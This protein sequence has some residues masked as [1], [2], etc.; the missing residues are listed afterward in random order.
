MSDDVLKRLAGTIH[1]RRHAAAD[2]SY[3]RQLLDGGVGECAKKFGE[4]AVETVLAAATEDDAALTREAADLLYHLL[5][6]LE[7]REIALGDVLK[8]LEERMGVSGLDEKA[9][10]G[11]GG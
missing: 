3:T 1:D 7:S 8:V 6:V 10:R 5:V 11:A 2:R 9:A 4:E